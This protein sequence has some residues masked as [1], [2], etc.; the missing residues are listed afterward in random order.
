MGLS[1][2]IQKN[3]PMSSAT[4][5]AVPAVT[6]PMGLKARAPGQSARLGL[7]S[8]DPRLAIVRGHARRGG[9]ITQVKFQQSLD[10]RGEVGVIKRRQTYPDVCQLVNP[11]AVGAL[12]DSKGIKNLRSDRLIE[13]F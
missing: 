13:V 12:R 3:G 4:N 7:P 10:P 5:T 6:D 8:R 11:R 9:L 2:S 1:Q